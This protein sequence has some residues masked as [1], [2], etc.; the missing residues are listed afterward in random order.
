MTESFIKS[1]RNLNLNQKNENEISHYYK[2]RFIYNQKDKRAPILNN[3]FTT[4]YFSKNEKGRVMEL[5]SK[6]IFIFFK[7]ILTWAKKSMMM[8]TEFLNRCL[9]RTELGHNRMCWIKCCQ[10]WPILETLWSFELKSKLMSLKHVVLHLTMNFCPTKRIE[11][12]RWYPH[13]LICNS[14]ALSPSWTHHRF[15]QVIHLLKVF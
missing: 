6:L 11:V 1:Y 13:P 12:I 15:K 7:I 4:N 10:I 3:I 14:T 8:Y 2:S 9:I 5:I